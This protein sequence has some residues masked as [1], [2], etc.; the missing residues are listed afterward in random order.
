MSSADA[1]YDINAEAGPSY[2]SP[3]EATIS[4]A[5]LAA[6]ALRSE[7]EAVAVLSTHLALENISV[8]EESSGRGARRMNLNGMNQEGQIG[9]RSES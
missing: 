9:P 3:P 7:E 6:E 4:A 1:P 8:A 2:L 5:L